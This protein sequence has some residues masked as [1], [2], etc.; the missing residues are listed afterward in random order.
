MKKISVILIIAV[1][2][3]VLALPVIAAKEDRGIQAGITVSAAQ[4][5]SQPQIVKRAVVGAEDNT[6]ANR[7]A[8]RE[9]MTD[10]SRNISQLREIAQQSREERAAVQNAS[11]V[12]SGWSKN[13]NEVRLA[14]HTLLAME[15]FTGGIG[16]QVSAIARD[17][18]NSASSTQRLEE[19]IKNRDAFSRFFFGGDRDAATELANITVQNG[20]RIGQIKQLMNTTSQD[21]ET[22]AMMEE[23]L[24]P[25]QQ[26]VARLE[27]LSAQEKQDRGLFGWMGR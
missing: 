3:S 25:L 23:Q 18:N 14:V 7:G 1:C 27:Q 12:R 19:R 21:P 16:P 6:T 9:N 5:N 17:F 4:D 26:E 8:I 11:P 15:N 22:R 2:L 13:E 10:N 24:Q 20:A